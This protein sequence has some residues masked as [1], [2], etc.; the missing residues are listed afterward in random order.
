MTRR[1]I[2]PQNAGTFSSL[3]FLRVKLGQYQ[4]AAK[5]ME[6]FDMLAGF[7]TSNAAEKS[8]P[9]ASLLHRGLGDELMKEG[10]R[11]L[12]LCSTTARWHSIGTIWARCSSAAC[13]RALVE[14]DNS[15]AD[16]D[17]EQLVNHPR[18]DEF[19]KLNPQG[20]FALLRTARACVDQ[21]RNINAMEY[22]QRAF[23]VSRRYHVR[24]SDSSYI[25]AVSYAAAAD[26]DPKLIP[27]AVAQLK[28]M[29][30]SASEEQKTKIRNW[31]SFS[32]AFGAA[33]RSWAIP[34]FTESD[35]AVLV[36][37]DNRGEPLR[38]CPERN[39]PK[40]EEEF[41]RKSKEEERKSGK[42]CA[43]GFD[44]RFILPSY[45]F[46]PLAFALLSSSRIDS[47]RKPAENDG[48]P[49]SN[50]ACLAFLETGGKCLRPGGGRRPWLPLG[51][52]LEWVSRD[53]SARSA[54]VTTE[55]PRDLHWPTLQHAPLS[56]S[57]VRGAAVDDST[58]H[59]LFSK[60]LR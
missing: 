34:C 20:I 15:D 23:E 35:R 45:L 33:R 19:L 41:E 24:E 22:A 36:G 4:E 8:S 28:A 58:S 43:T 51:I 6:R 26:A 25:L 5:D 2:D 44:N 38:V 12:A 50:P 37:S 1:K 29:Y 60:P 11:E 18:F 17:F 30:R 55:T 56:I 13:Q 31:Y 54:S 32:Q 21:G 39:T 27:T 57:R 46:F 40:T 47:Q 16:A 59:E 3:A 10:Q 52:A 49:R 7:E 14:R 42:P 48:A 53:E 9:Q